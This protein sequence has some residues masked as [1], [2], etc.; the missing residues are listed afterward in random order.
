MKK[1]VHIIIP[2]RNDREGVEQTLKSVQE[3]TCDREKIYTTAVDFAS[4]DG[5][6]QL[7]LSYAGYHVGVYQKAEPVS[8]DRMIAEAAALSRYLWPEGYDG[9]YMVLYPGDILY[10]DAI[11]LCM[12]EYE[13]HDREEPAIV[14]CEAD[15][16]ERDGSIHAQEHMFAQTR[17]LSAGCD[18][19]EYISR[20][21]DHQ[22]ITMSPFLFEKEHRDGAEMNEQ[23]WWNKCSRLCGQRN[24]LYI[25][26]PVG[27]I[28]RVRYEDDA[29]EI[30]LRWESVIAQIRRGRLDE[31]CREE[32]MENL[33]RYALW[34]SVE[35]YQE[36]G[37][38]RKA[39]DCF[40]LSSLIWPDIMV[41]E[42]YQSLERLLNGM[43]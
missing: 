29:E 37:A 21:Y 17:I 24:V 43:V 34:R 36:E 13:S 5:T 33:A 25:S 40:L 27:R 2:A 3:Q 19:R 15:I 6:Y 9:F 26:K 39:E 1:N 42:Q 11:Q 10:P 35:L 8:R 4:T 16:Q 18:T 14:L 28:K 22:I 12:K 30:L 7:L 23:R 32:S 38:C 31:S 41:Q 20:G